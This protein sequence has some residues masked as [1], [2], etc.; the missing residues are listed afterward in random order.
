MKVI[1]KETVVDRILRDL[2]EANRKG[3]MVEC[4]VVTSEEDR[5]LRKDV[6]FF[7]YVHS[8]LLSPFVNYAAGKLAVEE[9]KVTTRDFALDKRCYPAG[10]RRPILRVASTCTFQGVP[11]YVVPK[12][13]HP[14]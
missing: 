4:I 14:A 11:L 6:R 13:Y 1:L 7:D 9:L 5:E 3:R 10:A 2:S 12:E 8:D